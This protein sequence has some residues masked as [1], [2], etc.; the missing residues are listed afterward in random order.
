MD[1]NLLEDARNLH[2]DKSDL[3]AQLTL[4]SNV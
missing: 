3:E 4:L 2:I 1:P